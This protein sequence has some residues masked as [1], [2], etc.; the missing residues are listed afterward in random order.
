MKNIPQR[1]ST[2][3]ILQ[4]EAVECG[5]AALAIILGFYHCYVPLA[6]L[7][8]VCGVSRNG[9]KASNIV[10]AAEKYGLKA[11][12]YRLELESTQKLSPPF[13]AFWEFNHFVVLEGFEAQFVYINDPAVGRRRISLDEYDRS[14]TGIVLTFKPDTNFRTRGQ[15]P[16]IF[17]SLVRRFI[18]SNSKLELI[19]L[20]V[21]GFLLTIPGLA[22][23]IFSKTFIEN[24]LI[25]N[26]L[27]WLR[28]LLSFITAIA[29]LQLLLYF[30]QYQGLRRLQNR[31]S[32]IFS[33]EFIE[34]IL[35]LQ[36]SFYDQRSPG[37]IGSRFMLNNAVAQL[38]S[39]ELSKTLIDIVMMSVY[40]IIM[41]TYSIP[42]TLI[43]LLLAGINALGL[44]WFARQRRDTNLRL[45]LEM[46]QA[47]ATT[48]SGLQAIETIKGS[49]LETYFFNRWAGL[50]SKAINSQQELAVPTQILG[51]L[52]STLNSLTNMTLIIVGGLQ[53]MKG[54]MSLGMLVAFQALMQLFLEPI[55]R[56]VGMGS[57]LQEIFGDIAR[58]DDVLDNTVS[59]DQDFFQFASPTPNST[60]QVEF[61][62]LKLEGKVSLKNIFF[63][64]SPI[65]QPFIENF[66]L[67]IEPGQ[68]LAIVGGSGSGKSTIAKLLLG[69]Y[70]PWQGEILLDDIP[71]KTISRAVL[72]QSIGYVSQGSVIFSGTVQENITLWDKTISDL[73]LVQAAVDANIHLKIMTLP[74]GY[75]SYLLEGGMNLSGGERQ[76]LEIARSL[77]R[78]PTICI[79]DEAT[80]ALDTEA[81]EQVMLSL[82]SRG[83]TCIFIAHR[84]STIRDCDHILVMEKGKVVEQGTHSDLWQEK[85]AYYRMLSIQSE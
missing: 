5:A 79:F 48:I 25:E 10:K 59:K 8:Q 14:F 83:L 58:L 7:R 41:L 49:G 35:C 64:Y 51:I 42:L 6:E 26:R 37:E 43:A 80:S 77:V 54:E 21:A 84:L 70:Q 82:Q 33:A 18:K 52:P 16:K 24:V 53:V 27:D 76:R 57:I 2:P 44:H 3:T 50:Y 81:E 39:G 20:V 40:G 47:M 31:L 63:G 75:Q 36:T 19:Y 67:S 72:N 9:S 15:P 69:V 66:N 34:H 45:G 23:A 68:R 1:V 38:L 78:N 55:L 74:V 12:G 61:R 71:K 4:M 73:D 46:G 22:I 85:G 17:P 56:L 62:G 32:I 13:I 60:E 28:P 30:W 65:D 29:L 11:A